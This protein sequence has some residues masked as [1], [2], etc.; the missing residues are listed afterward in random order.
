MAIVT[1]KTKSEEFVYSYLKLV[2]AFMDLT[3]LELKV[4]SEFVKVYLDL[5]NTS[6]S[7]DKKWKTTFNSTS[8]KTV[9][10]N[11]GFKDRSNIDQ[12]IKKLKEKGVLI[13]SNGNT[14]FMIHPRA[15]PTDNIFGI[16][17]DVQQ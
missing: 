17:F 14:H 6:M 7:E 3:E 13:N 11:L 16:R 4:L 8:R 5:R 12:Y 9:Q 15:I 1:V 10:E 2:N